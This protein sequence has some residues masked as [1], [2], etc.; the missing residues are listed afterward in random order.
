MPEPTSNDASEESV[1]DHPKVSRVPMPFADPPKT[2]WIAPTALALSL[3]AA[4]AAGW[5][6][7][8]P[9]AASKTVT[10]DDPRAAVCKAFKTV[11]DAVYL[12]TNKVPNP[13]LGP[14][15][16]AAVEAIAANARLAMVGGS[17]FLLNNLPSNAPAELADKVR[18]FADNLDDI[19]MNALAGISNDRPD[20]TA[21]LRTAEETN[22]KIVEICK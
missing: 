14:A 4:V 21:L 20:Q 10:S 17:A 7:F 12:Q 22:K 2:G 8:K 13:D 5:S 11:S 15:T 19:G 18:A 16:P 6:L 9:S 3:L 1:R